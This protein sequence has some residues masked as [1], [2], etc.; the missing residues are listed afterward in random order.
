MFFGK[1][2][3]KILVREEVDADVMPNITSLNSLLG[4]SDNYIVYPSFGET[5]AAKK[6][7]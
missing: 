5:H 6:Y 2:G 7:R 3:N 4:N 1:E